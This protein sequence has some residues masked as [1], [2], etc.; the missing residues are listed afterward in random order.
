VVALPL[1]V[2]RALRE[3]LPGAVEAVVEE[4]MGGGTGAA[5]GSVALLMLRTRTTDG[6]V[7]EGRLA[8]K[9]LRPLTGGRHAAGAREPRHWAYWRREAEAY[10]S[11]LLPAGPG[12]RSPRCL[13]VEGNEI[14]L[15]VVGGP[16]PSVEQAAVHLAGWQITYREELDRPWLARDQLGQRLAVTDLDWS[17][18]DADPRVVRLWSRRQDL[19]D[20]LSRVP[21]VRSHGD[22][23]IGN[24]VARNGD[25]VALDWATFGWEPVG[26]DLAHLALST[27]RDPTGPYLAATSLPAPVVRRGF[28]AA[29]QLIGASRLHWMLSRGQ[30]V[31]DRYVDLIVGG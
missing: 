23:G 21:L 30:P 7:L 13:G 20:A 28:L 15:E 26:F 19:C 9:A 16:P 27:G 17:T 22:Y 5:T 10:T 11:G 29:I 8:K 1:S 2:L 12:L 14:Y 25:T 6:Q 4:P 24:L 18:V 31:P 3:V